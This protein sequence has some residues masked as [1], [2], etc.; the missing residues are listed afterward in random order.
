M[1]KKFIKEI[2]AAEDSSDLNYILYRTDGVDIMY[3]RGKLT[4]EQHEILFDLCGKLEK[5]F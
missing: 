2:V 1:F 4:W 5:L 3:Q